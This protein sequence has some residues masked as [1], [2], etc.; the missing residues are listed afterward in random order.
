MANY[1]KGRR[2]E[3]EV[4]HFLESMGFFVVR[5]AGSKPCDLVAF[6]PGLLPVFIECKVAGGQAKPP[7]PYAPYLLVRKRG[8]DWRSELVE[9]LRALG[10]V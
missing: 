2:F 1:H 3:Y 10:Y 7:Y 8:R 9:G 4:K 5:C 6:K